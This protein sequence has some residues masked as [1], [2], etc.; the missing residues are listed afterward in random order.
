MCDHEYHCTETVGFALM[1]MDLT[2]LVDI[3]FQDQCEERSVLTL[4]PIRVDYQFVSAGSVAS[5]CWPNAYLCNII[6]EISRLG[7]PFLVALSVCVLLQPW[8]WKRKTLCTRR[9]S[10]DLPLNLPR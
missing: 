1:M 2:M 6:F 5:W 3:L 7:C 9:S 8:T 10:L 4:E